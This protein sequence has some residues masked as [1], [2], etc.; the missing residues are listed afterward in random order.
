MNGI[1]YDA[2]ISDPLVVGRINDANNLPIPRIQGEELPHI[3]RNINHPDMGRQAKKKH[4]HN[5]SLP[6]ILVLRL[7][8]ILA[9]VHGANL[10]IR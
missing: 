9:A 10:Y 8:C 6:S 5:S 3:I 7:P 4:E 1:M 2:R